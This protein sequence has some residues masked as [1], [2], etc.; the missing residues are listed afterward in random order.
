MLYNTSVTFC[1]KIIGM[2]IPGRRIFMKAIG[3]VIVLHGGG[4]V[5]PSK[6]VLLRLARNLFLKG[7]YGKV[8]LCRYSFEGLLEPENWYE[9]TLELH[10]S[11]EEKRGTYFG[12]SRDTNLADSKYGEIAITNLKNFQINTVIVCGGDG[13]ARQLAEMEE[14]FGKRGINLIF[15]IPLTI[16][17]INGGESIGIKE[18]TS[19]S[20]RQIENMVATSLETRQDGGFGVVIAK[21][22]GRNRD[23]ILANVLDYFSKKRRIADIH[24]YDM[25]LITISANYP[26]NAEKLLKSVNDSKEKTLILLSEGARKQNDIFCVHKLE[27]SIKRKVR[28]VRIGHQ[29]QSNNMITEDNLMFYFRWVD[30][31]ADIIAQSPM[32]SYSIVKDGD[33]I[34]PTDLSYYAIHNP[35]EGQK[36][37]LSARLK[38]L[39]EKYDI[40]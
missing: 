2:L 30:R 20:I 3:N 32:G 5:E 15:P 36:P 21:L 1:N 19:E 10:E 13:S 9:Y 17:G 28:T 16:D 40:S 7:V 24:L 4:L 8:F 6:T 25:E 34:Y 12:T 22:Q 37:Q 39:V 38:K 23:D 33:E 11:W 26:T 31:V 27:K 14:E 35:R 29:S 18:A